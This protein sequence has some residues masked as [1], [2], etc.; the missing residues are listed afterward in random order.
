MRLTTARRLR[1]RN[2]ILWTIAAALAFISCSRNTV[3]SH[4]EPVSMD[5]WER[6]DTLYY[7]VATPLDSGLFS[8]YINIR[9]AETYPYQELTLGALGIPDGDVLHVVGD[10]KDY[11]VEMDY[12]LKS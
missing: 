10:E 9:V 11:Y 6:S 8:S 2:N 4:Y 7:T 1:I 3:Y 5:G 12:E